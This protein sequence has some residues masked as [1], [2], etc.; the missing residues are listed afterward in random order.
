MDDKLYL[1]DIDR[2]KY[3]SEEF[4]AFFA[5]FIE[6]EPVAVLTARSS[7]DV[8]EYVVKRATYFFGANGNEIYK[9]GK[10]LYKNVIAFNT[11]THRWVDSLN[12]P[13]HRTVDAIHV[14]ADPYVSA[15]LVREYN[16]LQTEYRAQIC[17]SGLCIT[18]PA[19]YRLPINAIIPD[20]YRI[21]FIAPA[22]TFGGTN[23]ALALAISKRGSCFN[24]DSESSLRELLLYLSEK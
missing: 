18:H 24:A 6:D 11:E 7:C 13:Q 21:R 1:L 20:S 23:Y 3:F 14:S 17:A 4:N 9:Q 22:T 10:L 5:N 19:D 2:L 16:E 8:P 12:L 15:K